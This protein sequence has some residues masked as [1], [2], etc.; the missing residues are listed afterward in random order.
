MQLIQ[1][2][3]RAHP[4][5]SAHDPAAEKQLHASILSILTPQQQTQFKAR[6][7]AMRAEAGHGHNWE[8]RGGPEA[9]MRGPMNG[10]T[11]SAAQKAEMKTLR[12]QFRTQSFNVLTPAQQ[13]QYRQNTAAMSAGGALRREGGGM[14]AGITLTVDQQ[15]KIKALMAS[16]RQAHEGMRP[17]P[18][19]RQALRT[20]I[21][22]V[23]TPAQ[24]VRFKAN[25]DNMKRDGG[26]FAPDPG[27]N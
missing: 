27:G 12:E 6:M 23:L 11:L 17:D 7:E 5:G 15:A 22:Q 20:Q 14:M 2:Y 18:A 25:A 1:Q 3:H 16:F 9:R 10:I 24:Q 21:M 8:R 4:R 19:A 26:P 13:A